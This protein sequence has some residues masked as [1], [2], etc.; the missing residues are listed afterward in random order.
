REALAARPGP[1][2]ARASSGLDPIAAVAGQDQG[3]G[4]VFHSAP[5]LG[6][7]GAVRLSLSPEA[8]KSVT[9]WP[10]RWGRA[11]TSRGPNGCWRKPRLLRMRPFLPCCASCRTTAKRVETSTFLLT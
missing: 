9:A 8:R 5:P 6:L 1:T 7:I 10:N 2:L 4:K 3:F 11:C